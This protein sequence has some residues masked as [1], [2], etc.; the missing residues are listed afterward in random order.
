MDE[1]EYD[2]LEQTGPVEW[3]S[4]WTEAVAASA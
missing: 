1:C 4:S 2:D 3:R